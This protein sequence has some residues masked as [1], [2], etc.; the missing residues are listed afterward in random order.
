MTAEEF[1]KTMRECLA[2]IYDRS[3][4]KDKARQTLKY[5][6]RWDATEFAY[7]S[8]QNY[9]NIAIAKTTFA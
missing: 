5:T 7:Q 9:R 1:S 4:L 6:G 3:V 8:N 2:K